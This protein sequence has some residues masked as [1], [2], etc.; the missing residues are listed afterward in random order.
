MRFKPGVTL[1]EQG[2]WKLTLGNRAAP[3]A[4]QDAALAGAIAQGVCEVDRLTALIARTRGVG[5]VDAAIDLAQFILD[6]GDFI[7]ERPTP[8]K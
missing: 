7:A 2:G 6:Y 4:P 3:V 8:Q 5:E 1:T